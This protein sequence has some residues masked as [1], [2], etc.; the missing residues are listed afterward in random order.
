MRVLDRQLRRRYAPEVIDRVAYALPRPLR[1]W[2]VLVFV[3]R[4][5][6][7]PV[8]KPEKL[9]PADLADDQVV[10]NA[11][12]LANKWQVTTFLERVAGAPADDPR[13]LLDVYDL[14]A[15]RRPRF[16]VKTVVRWV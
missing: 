12:T 3:F 2:V 11:T 10:V 15:G 5:G 14:D 4:G 16:K 7:R 8:H 1:R 9:G 13:R 6:R